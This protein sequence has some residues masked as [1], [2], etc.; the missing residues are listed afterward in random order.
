MGEL[1]SK[2][3]ITLTLKLRTR[4]VTTSVQDP[5]LADWTNEEISSKRFCFPILGVGCGRRVAV[6][7]AVPEVGVNKDSDFFAPEHQIR[8][9]GNRVGVGR[10]VDFALL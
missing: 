9:A 10:E 3:T 1:V 8:L 7:V 6:R 5:T 2:W 4:T